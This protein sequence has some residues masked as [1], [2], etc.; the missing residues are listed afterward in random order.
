MSQLRVP[1]FGED[2]NPKLIQDVVRRV[3]WADESYA[4]VKAYGAAG[5][6]LNDDTAAIQAAID[7]LSAGGTVFMPSGTYKITSPLTLASRVPLIGAGQHATIISCAGCG[8]ATFS[9]SDNLN[10]DSWYIRMADMTIR[11]DYTA[12]QMGVDLDHIVHLNLERVRIERFAGNGLNLYYIINSHLIDCCLRDND[13]AGMYCDGLVNNLTM[14]GGEV[15]ANNGWGVH[16]TASD[17][18][19]YTNVGHTY[20]G[21]DIENNCLGGVT[22]D[23]VNALTLIGNHFEDNKSSNSAPA[24]RTAGTVPTIGYHVLVGH[25]MTASAPAGVTILGNYFSDIKGSGNE[26]YPIRLTRASGVE[27]AGN[28]YSASGTGYSRSIYNEAGNTARVH[29]SPGEYYAGNVRETCGS[30]TFNGTTGRV[31]THQLRTGAGIYRVIITPIAPV[32][33]HIHVDKGTNFQF[34]VYST[35]AAD[36]GAFDW[37]MFQEA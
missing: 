7:A 17:G 9:G 10:D 19:N 5:D 28:H 4:N 3:N 16:L 23:Y 18:A 15:K 2:P 37:M 20:I 1:G 32:A 34:T 25:N 26:G 30:S 13:L 33:G 27:I 8:G 22:A 24:G 35:E 11:G 14:T 21:V 6:G 31:I 12:V 29:V 36:T